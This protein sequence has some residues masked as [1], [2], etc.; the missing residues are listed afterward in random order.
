M[1]KVLSAMMELGGAVCLKLEGKEGK[2]RE[3]SFDRIRCGISWPLGNYPGYFC[4]V[5]LL[6]G[7]KP[8]QMD[9]LIFLM[10]GEEEVADDLLRKVINAA[11]DLRFSEFFTDCRKPEWVAFCTNMGRHLRTLARIYA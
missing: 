11:K 6:S 5:G 7:A 10:E 9:S 4:V 8:G 3:I 1:E 2:Q